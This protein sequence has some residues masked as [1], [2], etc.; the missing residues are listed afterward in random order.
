MTDYIKKIEEARVYDIA[1]KTPL[2]EAKKIS[3]KLK[4]T[5]YLKREDLQ[6]VFSFKLR[7]AYNKITAL[8]REM[9]KRGIVAASAGNHAQGVALSAQKLG[10]P[11]TIVMPKT[12]PPIKV[13]SVKDL[14]ASAILVGDTYDDAFQHAKSLSDSEN[15][16]FISPYD[17]PDVIAGQGTIAAE[18]VDQLQPEKIDA[19]FVP[20]GGGGLIAGISVFLKTK[21]PHIKIIGVEPENSNCLSQALKAGKRVILP[22]V[23]IFADGVAVKQIGKEPFR[24]AKKYVDQVVETTT[25]EICSA[26]K[27]IYDETRAITEP[28]GALAL[29]GIKKYIKE[30]GSESETYIAIVSGA[31]I[32]FDRLRHVSERADFG[33]Y[34]EAIFAVK[35][36]E[37]PG[38]FRRFC[39]SIGHR[40]VT[41][42]N[43]RYANDKDAM[44]FVGLELRAGRSEKDEILRDLNQ[45]GFEV[46]DLTQ[47]EMAKLHIRHM[48]GGRSHSIDNERLYRFQFPERPGAL[49]E[50]LNGL[51]E[52]WNISLFHYRN[53]GAAYGRVLAGIQV[54]DPEFSEFTKMLEK[55]N[56]NY[57]DESENK[58]YKLFL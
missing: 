1:S 48:V 8:P 31:N 50:F 52:K 15:L 19:V 42:F 3:E 30:N 34:R 43:Y 24:L 29:S 40:S 9:I 44:V 53:H 38:S 5:I 49:V 20:V 26:I 46:T 56:F 18:I 11:A 12:T 55:L 51:G 33:S 37:V 54:S 13:Q 47:N 23:G 21:F 27:D 7:G 14:G 2:T 45:K 6:P 16:P 10:I 39:K 35:I 17:D 28:A 25:D 32:N 4:N 57:S 36:P 22:S 58:A 41:E